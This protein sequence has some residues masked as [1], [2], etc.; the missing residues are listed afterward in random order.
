LIGQRRDN[1]AVYQITVRGGLD[2]EWGDILGGLS[3]RMKGP[4]TILTGPVRDQPALYGI[5]NR[6]RDLGLELISIE[7][8]ESG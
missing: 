7:R 5:V 2:A 8:I 6:L 1:P 3:V 4:N